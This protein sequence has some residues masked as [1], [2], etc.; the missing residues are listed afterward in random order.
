MLA[1]ERLESDAGRGPNLLKKWKYIY[2]FFLPGTIEEA[3]VILV[4]AAWL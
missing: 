3:R 1:E 2:I 4:R